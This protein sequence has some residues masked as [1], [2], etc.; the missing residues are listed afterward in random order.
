MLS[1]YYIKIVK[2]V[3]QI[4]INVATEEAVYGNHKK[5]SRCSFYKDSQ[6]KPS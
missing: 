5:V 6:G 1:T 3:R 2:K 4:V